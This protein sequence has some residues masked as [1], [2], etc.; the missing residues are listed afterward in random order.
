[1]QKCNEKYRST[2][3]NYKTQRR[4]ETFTSN[5][6]LEPPSLSEIEA[7]LL[8]IDENSEIKHFNANFVR[9][10]NA[11]KEIICYCCRKPGHI[12]PYCP[13]LKKKRENNQK[14]VQ[15]NITQNSSA[16]SA[17][18]VV[19]QSATSMSKDSV[20]GNMARHGNAGRKLS[21]KQI[22]PHIPMSND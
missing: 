14:M 19:L 7:A 6:C 2:V 9:N 8:S 15:K 5:Y 1:M 16:N 20:Q 22:S 12:R 17:Q 21:T 11:K 4:N 10:T 13:L 18:H 3:L